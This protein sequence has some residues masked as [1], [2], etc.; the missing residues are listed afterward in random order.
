MN[1]GKYNYNPTIQEQIQQAYKST[2]APQ[3]K[4]RPQSTRHVKIN[5]T[6]Q[7]ITRAAQLL[8]MLTPEETFEI[9]IQTMDA[10]DALLAIRAAEIYLK[11]VS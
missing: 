6:E 8:S 7:E 10:E 11:D 9:L 2:Q 1:W 5:P 3:K 4:V